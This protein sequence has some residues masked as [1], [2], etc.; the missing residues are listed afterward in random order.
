MVIEKL[1]I[2]VV[3]KINDIACYLKLR[4]RY[5]KEVKW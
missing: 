2:R 5:I 3:E 4:K 1:I